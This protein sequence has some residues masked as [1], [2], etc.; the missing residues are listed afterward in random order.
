MSPEKTI[1]AQDAF[2]RG[3]L[4]L[5]RKDWTEAVGSFQKAADLEPEEGKHHIFLGWALFL[6]SR[7][8]E[9]DAPK[10]HIDQ[11]L[12]L[13][14][15]VDIGW[16]FMGHW[17]KAQQD[18]AQAEK[19][20]SKAVSLNPNNPEAASELRLTQKRRAKRP[21]LLGLFGFFKKGK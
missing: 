3:Q 8:K 5:K 6:K 7:R 19:C 17:H 9:L 18:L 16:L 2:K 10:E 15:D 21:G 20:Y 4:A 12:K 14:S 1:Q 11:G 13:T